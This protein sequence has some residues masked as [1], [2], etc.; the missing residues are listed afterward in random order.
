MFAFGGH[1]ALSG[2]NVGRLSSHSLGTATGIGGR[3]VEATVFGVSVN[4]V[5]TWP[6]STARA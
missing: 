1:A 3:F 5:A 6:H 2:R 4:D